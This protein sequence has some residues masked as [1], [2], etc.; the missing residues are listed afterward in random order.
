MAT[1]PDDLGGSSGTARLHRRATAPEP[2]G[3]ESL[4][5]KYFGDLRTGMLGVW[6]GAIQ[7]MYPELGAGVEDHSVLLREPLQRVARSV[8]PI[9]GVVYD[10]PRATQTG[11]QIKGYHTTIKGID[12]DGRRYHALNPETF[13]WAHATFFMLIIKTAEYFCGGLTEAEKRQLFAEHV[14]WYSMYGMSMRPVPETWED[15]CEYWDRKC[16]EELEIN[17]ATLDI[18]D[19]RIPKPRF[20]L[21]P[22]PLWDQLFRPMVAG[23]RWIAAGLFDPAVREKAGMRWTPGDEVVLR[24]F[25]KLV[26]LAFVA[27][28]DEIRL[29]PRA[30]AAYRRAQGRLPDDAPLVEAPAF[31]GPPR[32]RRGLPM[33]YVPRG[34]TI[35]DRAGS[36]VHTTFSLAGLRPA[37]ARRTAA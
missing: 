30:L 3:P 14:Q 12:G 27:V 28:P 10:G 18:F 24:L 13:Y 6:I 16:R 9:M 23:Q 32:D 29:H 11:E 17:K 2:L 31:M 26:E 36:L 7:N 1:T 34:K 15:F 25:G 8:Y 4:T 21:M 20:V 19:I 35:L 33:H 37:R 5:W 22:T